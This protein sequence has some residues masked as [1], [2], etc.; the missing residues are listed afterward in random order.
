MITLS[1]AAIEAMGFRRFAPEEAIRAAFSSAYVY[2]A[3]GI[4]LDPGTVTK[5]SAVLHR[6]SYSVG[7]GAD[8][9]QLAQGL[10]NEDYTDDIAAWEKEH[11]CKPPY[12]MIVVG[13]TEE[14]ECTEGYLKAES[15]G[16]LTYNCF[17]DARAELAGLEDR[18]IPPL[19]AGFAATFGPRQPPVKFVKID[20]LWF[21]RST[22]GRAINDIR[23]DSTA[24]AFI[25]THVSADDVQSMVDDSVALAGRLNKKIAQFYHLA[26]D[27]TDLLKRFLYFFLSIEVATHATFAS[28]DHAAHIS[29]L[30]ASPARLQ[31]SLLGF[32]VSQRQ[33][34]TTL[35]DRFVWCALCT[36]THLDDADV[37]AFTDLKKIRD[38]IAHGTISGPPADAV[39]IVQNL[40]TRIHSGNRCADA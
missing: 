20:R 8:L 24:T 13:P 32:L 19:S 31:A 37:S 17:P 27:E 9:N 30:L 38:K 40:A 14:H 35:R 16:V 15:E 26:L 7:L 3:Q 33:N 1:S 11:T 25:S 10:L 22:D 39:A 28:I 34:W 6:V 36:W 18:I 12:L 21:G 4:Q 5:S 29:L 2:S 23:V